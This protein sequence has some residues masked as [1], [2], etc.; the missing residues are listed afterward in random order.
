MNMDKIIS[1]VRGYNAGVKWLA[2]NANKREAIKILVKYASAISESL[3]ERAY[4]ELLH[5]TKGFIGDGHFDMAGLRTV[6]ELR[7]R[8]AR[9]AKTLGHP[10]KYCD[11]SIVEAALGN[12][13][14]VG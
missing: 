10:T 5:P 7:M 1:Y 2:E 3:A 14:I 11:L 13:A 8:Y 12:H 9:P 6:L 4:A